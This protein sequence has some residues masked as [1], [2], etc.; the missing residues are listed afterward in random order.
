MMW[1]TT[2]KQNN[3]VGWYFPLLNINVFFNLLYEESYGRYSI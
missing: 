1:I 2:T 3:Q